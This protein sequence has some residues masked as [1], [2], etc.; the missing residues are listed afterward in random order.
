[1]KR[2]QLTLEQTDIADFILKELCGCTVKDAKEILKYVVSE[3]DERAVI[4]SPME[5]K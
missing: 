5:A 2:E 4:D 3:L 1:M